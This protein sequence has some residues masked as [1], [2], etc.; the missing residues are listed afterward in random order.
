[1]ARG[2]TSSAWLMATFGDPRQAKDAM[3]ALERIGVPTRDVR[4]L[5]EPA[6]ADGHDAVAASGRKAAW[7]RR[8]IVLGAI[9]GAV[10]GAALLGVITAVFVHDPSATAWFAAA[11]VGVVAGAVVGG[12]VGLV[13][14]TPRNPRAWDT[15]LVAHRGET[16][17]AVAVRASN[18]EQLVDALRGAGATSTEL[19]PL[20]SSSSS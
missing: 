17:L 1:M 7:F 16:C 9:A 12:F 5:G 19:V 15:Y 20:A 14:R 11:M 10:I 18:D 4:L 6:A 8:T 13:G 2:F 3:A